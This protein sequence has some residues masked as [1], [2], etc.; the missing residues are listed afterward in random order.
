MKYEEIEFKNEG[1]ITG[2]VRLEIEGKN[3]PNSTG[4]LT[5]E[6]NKF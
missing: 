6:P 1:R 2:T 5:I 4:S 3:L